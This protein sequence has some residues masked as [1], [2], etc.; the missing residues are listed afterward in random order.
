[1]G[2]ERLIYPRNSHYRFVERSVETDRILQI[3]YKKKRNKKKERE[4]ITRYLRWP[5]LWGTS[6]I[7]N[8]VDSLEKLDSA[9]LHYIKFHKY[10]SAAKYKENRMLQTPYWLPQHRVISGIIVLR[11]VPVKIL[12]KL[13]EEKNRHVITN[14]CLLSFFNSSAQWHRFSLAEDESSDLECI[15]FDERG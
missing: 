13:A 15:C 8:T 1:M 7:V 9:K 2:A 12:W 10:G 5:S 3:F 11:H 14:D 4:N 6:S